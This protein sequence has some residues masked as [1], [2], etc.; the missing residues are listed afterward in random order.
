MLSNAQIKSL[1]PKRIHYY[2]T[3]D[4]GRRGYGRLAVRTFP[5]GSKV[6][7][8]VYTF[9]K[10]RKYLP[11]GNYPTLALKD[12]RKLAE[13]YG[14]MVFD[15]QDPREVLD[16]RLRAEEA[17]R[18]QKRLKS[19]EGNIAQ[20]FTLFVN[21][22]EA[23]KSNE[24]FKAV[25]RF[26]LKD[27]QTLL[28]PDTKACDVKKN[29]IVDVLR[30]IVARGSLVMANRAR[31]YLQAAFTFGLEYDS[32]LSRSTND[33]LFNLEFNPVATVPKAL[34]KEPVSDR[35]LSAE[36]LSQFWKLIEVSKLCQER[37]L[38][39][40]LLIVFG[41]RRV[42]E[43]ILAPWGE[44]NLTKGEWNRP[45]SRDKKSRYTLMPI[46]AM[47]N[48]LLHELH[49]ITG[50]DTYLFGVKPPSD[51]AINQTIR[52]LIKGKMD[53]FTPK[54]LRAT[55]KTLMGEIGISKELRDRYH[56]HALSDI[57]SRHYD[58]YD[59]FS[60]K[61]EVVRKWEAFLADTLNDQPHNP[62]LRAV[63]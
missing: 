23:T 25:K 57:S 27:A 12:A 63:G 34:K 43:V 61:K 37:K 29:D 11:L 35:A 31:A 62:G 30:P 50:T 49:E 58:K 9:N 20:L 41:G 54:S 8:L 60:E 5:N 7:Y 42:K 32:S 38:L 4:S 51:Y 46:G 2:T 26:L 18:Q 48:S 1:K 21:H 52:R 3:D 44:F 36:E 55:A 28:G 40:K 59:Y 13:D 39:L 33:V 24:H 45:G 15:G 53:H 22:T 6:F 10:K 56:S 47:A 19:L 14:Q 16:A 17:A